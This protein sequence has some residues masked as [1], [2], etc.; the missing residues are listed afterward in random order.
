MVSPSAVVAHT[1]SPDTAPGRAAQQAMSTQST[2]ERVPTPRTPMAMTTTRNFG[3]TAQLSVSVFMPCAFVANAN[4][5]THSR[6]PPA[7]TRCHQNLSSTDLGMLQRTALPPVRPYKGDAI[8][9]W[10][11]AG[12]VGGTSGKVSSTCRLACLPAVVR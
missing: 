3:E 1:R 2:M 7:A 6:A 8:S 10:A 11:S 5:H 9:E 12:V 4:G